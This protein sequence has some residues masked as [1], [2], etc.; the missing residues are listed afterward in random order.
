MDIENEDL[1]LHAISNG[2]NLF[3]GAGFS[4]LAKAG[5]R[6]LPAGDALKNELIDHFKRQKPS[7]LSLAQ[8][9]QIISSTQRDEFY[10]YINSRF[11]VTDFPVE[12]SNLERV[13]ISSIF[14]TNIDDLIPKIFS[15][16]DKYYINDILLRGPVIAGNS[17]IDYIPLHGSLNHGDGRYD[18]SPLEISSS[19]SRDQDKWYGYIVRIQDTPTLYWGYRVDDAGVLQALAKSPLGERKRAHSWVVL[20]NKDVEAAEYYSSLGFQIIIADTIELLNYFGKLPKK[21]IT[22]THQTLFGK[23]FSEYKIPALSTIPVRSISEFYLGA[24]PTWYDI[25]SGKIYETSYFISATNIISGKKNLVLIGGAVTGKTTLLRQLA[26]RITGFGVPLYIEVITPE[27]ARLISRDIDAEGKPVIA[28]IDNAAD[29]SEAIQIMVTSKNIKIVAAER[30]YIF[31]SVAHRF[32]SAQFETLD[33][34]F[35]RPIDIQ[36]IENRIPADINRRPYFRAY[37]PLN[38]DAD[39]TFLEFYSLTIIENSL[40]DRFLEAL[41]EYRVS[42]LSAHDILVLACYCYA[43]RIPIS[44]DIATAYSRIYGLTVFEVSASLE[45]MGSMLSHYEGALA[46]SRQSYYV[47]RSR[48]LAEVVLNRIPVDDLRRVLEVF[49]TEVSPTK[50]G[51]YDVFRR[52]GY[53]AKLIGRAFPD[54]K[55]GLQ[56]YEQAFQRDSSYSLKQQGALY[57]A[58]KRNFQQ[59]FMWID[60]ARSM[61]RNNPAISNSYAVILFNANYDKQADPEV[62]ATLDE[63]MNILKSCYDKDHRKVYHAK[64]FADQ[65]LKYAAK[66]PTSSSASEYL[67]SSQ[68]WLESELN[69][70]PGDRGMKN[71]LRQV[72][73][74]LRS[75]R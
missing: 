46:E 54:W 13:N 28:F 63:S 14:T 68:R 42:K 24:E 15:S 34:S 62:K 22:N 57:L 60:E 51:R 39:P 70:R 20:R 56:F 55:E 75:F 19:F 9:C 11:T 38:P 7:K 50:I 17:A 27:K 43:S 6:A 29:A 33:I 32:P 59:A 48:Q 25:Y 26:T 66:F 16:S 69:R 30:D 45:S 21:K 3:L 1:F 36:A 49:H 74:Q 72:K 52:G 65:S 18:F 40:A 10:K 41:K 12:Y 64:V 47:P 8:L 35:L 61:T 31:D 53:D 44:V 23:H 37:D 58:H 73:S 5:D 71:L 67:K 2:I 4:V